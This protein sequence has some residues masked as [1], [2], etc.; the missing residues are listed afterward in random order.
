MIT[1]IHKGGGRSNPANYRLILLLPLLS[2]VMEAFGSDALSAYLEVFNFLTPKQH[3][4]R[5]NQSCTTNLLLPRSSW[6]ETVDSGI[7]VDVVLLDF[8]KALDQLD[9]DT[10]ILKLPTFGTAILS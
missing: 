1:P 2:K 8:L 5:R 3:G 6:T 10:L 7:E 9:P 4:F